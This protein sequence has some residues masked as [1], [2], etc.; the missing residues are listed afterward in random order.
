METLGLTAATSVLDTLG[1]A[2]ILVLTFVL[3]YREL[4]SRTTALLLGATLC[5]VW[6][7]ARG[8]FPATS[9]LDAVSLQTL[10]L[11]VTM[12]IISNTLAAGGLFQLVAIHILRLSGGEPRRLFV[13]LCS[14]TYI[15][16]L[17]ADNLTVMI[18][19]G[20]LTIG[21][22]TELGIDARPFITG[23][24]I[25]TNTGGAST[26]IGDFPNLILSER[27]GIPFLAFLAPL[28]M[29]WVCLSIQVFATAFLVWQF[30]NALRPPEGLASILT[31]RLV[32]ISAQRRRP[33]ALSSPRAVASGAVSLTVAIA[34]F[35]TSGQLHNLSPTEIGL[36]AS[37]LALGASGLDHDEIIDEVGLRHVMAFVGLFVLAGA[38]EST[39][40]IGVLGQRLVVL[41]GGDPLLTALA[42][43]VPVAVVTACV[44]AGP[45]T[46]AFV[47][48]I[49]SLNSDLGVSNHLLWWALSLGVLAG[50]SAT[51]LG[52]TAGTIAAAQIDGW[53]RATGGEARLNGGA[54]DA[55]ARGFVAG[56]SRSGLPVAVGMIVVAGIF[57]LLGFSLDE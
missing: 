4:T 5:I 3:V 44:D 47:P 1:V 6:G 28:G 31:A 34:L 2:S 8:F 53:Y 45:T 49:A 9:A 7:T 20:A 41:T 52:A 23:V 43:I 25:S 24:L 57:L 56:F 36:L 50:S 40:V 54:S 18:I 29:F 26:A 37:L 46:A 39:G 27:G 48:L 17:V 12:T 32:V 15:F 33:T 22:V 30:R 11:L 19:S 14:F 10:I 38:A 42:I 55:E 51:I 16:S 35:A 13:M 21:L